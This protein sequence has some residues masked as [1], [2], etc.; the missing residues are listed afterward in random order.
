MQ[1]PLLMF[2][3][4]CSSGHNGRWHIGSWG[5]PCWPIVKA[6]GRIEHWD[7]WVGGGGP[8]PHMSLWRRWWWHHDSSRSHSLP[9]VRIKVK[10]SQTGLQDMRNSR[11]EINRRKTWNCP[12]SLDGSGDHLAHFWV[13]FPLGEWKN[14]CLQGSMTWR[15]RILKNKF[16]FSKRH[17]LLTEFFSSF[18]LNHLKKE[19]STFLPKFVRVPLFLLFLFSITEKSPHYVFNVSHSW[20]AIP[21]ARR[22]SPSPWDCCTAC[23]SGLP[24]WE[25]PRQTS[26]AK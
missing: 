24:P 25:T 1:S 12:Q 20:R 17:T 23:S 6:R 5:Q 4:R 15:R 11:Q 16:S 18:F 9:D 10:S 8:P 14:D 19:W 7:P 3:T 22:P 26:S 21:W 2:A 13:S